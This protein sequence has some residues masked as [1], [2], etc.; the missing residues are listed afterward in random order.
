MKYI[1]KKFNDE[2]VVLDSNTF[3]RCEFT[4]CTLE[5][6][7]GKP[8]VMKNCGLTESLF[9]FS[10]QA[11]DTIAFLTGMYHGGFKTV[12]EETFDQIRKPLKK[13]A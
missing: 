4:N 7:G 13:D 12:I 6:S 11:S 10:D 9:S 5:Y 1:E 3:D 2:T 8:P